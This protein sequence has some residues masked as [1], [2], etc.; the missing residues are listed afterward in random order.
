MKTNNWKGYKLNELFDIYTSKDHNL[1]ESSEGKTPYISS[2]MSNNGVNR[3][4]SDRPTQE[5]F[6]ITIARNGSVGSAFYHE[7][8][9]CASPDDVRVLR[10]KFKINKYIG[11]FLTTIIEKEKFHYAYGRKFGTKRMKETIIKL[12]SLSNDTP[13]WK[14]IENYVKKELIPKLPKNARE[15]WSNTFKIN[16]IINKKLKLKSYNWKW[17]S[18]DKIFNIKKGR[19]LTIYEMEDGDI[20]YIASG[21]SNNG[22]IAYICNDTTN[23][24]GCI[25][26]ACYGSIGE[27]FYHDYDIWASDNVNVLT[28]KNNKLN[29]YIGL[30]IIT[31]LN[32]EKYRFSYGMTA[33]V[34][35]LKHFKI[36]LPVKSDDSPDWQFM[37]NYIKSLPYSSN[38]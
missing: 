13:D 26:I 28:L 35:R 18:Y 3:F 34:S 7:Y 14:W 17:F 24:K 22:I 29:K 25:T 11:I 10:P 36:K 8:D 6:S 23:K 38:L 21:S 4:I 1:V 5:K 33:K 27:V 32:L 2:T 30:F 9:F 12:P 19:R 37:E 15:K 31:L 20:P 16:P